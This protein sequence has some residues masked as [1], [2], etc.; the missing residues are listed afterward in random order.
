M[1]VRTPEY[2]AR[3]STGKIGNTFKLGSHLS[4][5][6]KAKMSVSRMGNTNRLGTS[7]TPE[8]RMKISATLTGRK[9]SPEAWE[10]MSRAQTGRVVSKETRALISKNNT[11]REVSL[12]TRR[13]MSRAHTRHGHGA[14]R[15]PTYRSW[16]A[17][18][19]R[20]T[21]VNHKAYPNYGGRGITVCDR[22][23]HSFEAFLADMGIRPDGMTLDR[24][25]ND[26]NYEPSNCR[27]ATPKEQARNKRR[28]RHCSTC[29]CHTT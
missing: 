29:T 2:L 9:H 16:Q 8:T 18:I 17:M 11:G 4:E 7:Q 5:E 27:W 12:E 21:S 20:C 14:T 6:T 24:I 1:Y 23:H 26:G 19:A 22:W 15:S 3:L 10:N 25:N 13:K 28:R